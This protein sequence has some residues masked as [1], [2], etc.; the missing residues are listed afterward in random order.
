MKESRIRQPYIVHAILA[1]KSAGE[2][3]RLAAVASKE[4]AEETKKM[5]AG[6]GRSSYIPEDETR[7]I[8]DPG[9]MAVSLWMEA[10]AE[11]LGKES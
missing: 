9:A 5:T 7:G 2:A 10:I 11:V 1:G 8:P 3:V 6:A 4:G